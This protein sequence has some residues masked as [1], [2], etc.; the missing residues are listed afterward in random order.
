MTKPLLTDEKRISHSAGIATPANH[1]VDADPALSAEDNQHWLSFV[2]LLQN[3]IAQDLHLP[4]LQLMLT[5]D[6]RTALGTRVRIIEELMRGEL[7]Q[8]ELKNQ[9]GAGIA[10]ITRGSNS[11]KAAPPQL[12]SWL[13]AQL[14]ADKK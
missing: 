13:E 7:S 1:P 3:A 10:T 14:L 2:A 9:L 4:L 8:R 12:K 11:L 5:P 6:E